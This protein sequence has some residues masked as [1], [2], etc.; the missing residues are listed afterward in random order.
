MSGSGGSSHYSQYSGDGSA[1]TCEKLN[2]T[3]QLASPKEEVVEQLEVGD[4]LDII[5]GQQNGQSVVQAVWRGQVAGGVADQRLQQLRHCLTEGF[6]YEALVLSV[7]NG[8]VRIRISSTDN[9]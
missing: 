4:L 3:T 5:S 1:D 2:F 8:Q 6:T 7:D 9:N